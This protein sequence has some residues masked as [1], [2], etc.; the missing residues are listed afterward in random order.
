MWYNDED[1]ELPNANER[2]PD[3]TDVEQIQQTSNFN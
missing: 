2:L 1:R 3:V